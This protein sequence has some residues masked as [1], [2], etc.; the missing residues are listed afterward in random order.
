M[1]LEILTAFLQDCQKHG[2]EVPKQLQ[3]VVEDY[4]EKTHG[5]CTEN[6]ND[7]EYATV[8][9]QRVIISRPVKEIV[10]RGL[11]EVETLRDGLDAK[12]DAQLQQ[13]RAVTQAITIMR[14]NII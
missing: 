2:V 14:N 5:F 9:G 12:D 11:Q 4:T 3:F 7:C 10:E 13:R 8:N 6:V 1:K